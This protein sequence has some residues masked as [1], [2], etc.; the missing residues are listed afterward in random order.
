MYWDQFDVG[1]GENPGFGEVYCRGV[2]QPNDPRVAGLAMCAWVSAHGRPERHR[3]ATDA[4]TGEVTSE[5][6]IQHGGVHLLQKRIQV[7]T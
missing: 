1:Y 6:T 5:E 4:W 2:A 3:K 7:P